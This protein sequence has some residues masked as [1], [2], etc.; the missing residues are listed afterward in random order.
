M[1]MALQ[2]SIR[3]SAASAALYYRAR[4]LR[5]GPDVLLAEAAVYLARATKSTEVHGALARAYQL[6]DGAGEQPGVLLHLRDATSQ[7]TREL[8]WG[9]GYSHDSSKRRGI[10]YLSASLKR[11]DLFLPD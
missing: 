6:I 1:A 11:T 4:M 7:L 8:G 9:Q 5:Q 10:E 3:G 2:K